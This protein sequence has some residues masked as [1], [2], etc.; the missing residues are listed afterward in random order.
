MKNIFF[1]LQCCFLLLLIISANSSRAQYNADAANSKLV[2]RELAIPTSPLFDLMGAA[3]S[4]VARTADIKDFKVDWSLKN[5]KVNPN[6]SIQAQPVWELFY[7]RKNLAKYQQANTFQRMM[8]SLDLSLGT[9]LGDN[10]ERRIGGA[11]KMSLY[12]QRDPLLMK[13]VYDDIQK[14]F[15]EELLQLKQKEKEIL[16]ALDSIVKPSELAAKREELRNN[17][18]QLTSFYSRRNTAIQNQAAQFVSDNWNAAYVD[19]AFGKIYSYSTDSAGSLGKLSLNRNTGN[20]L[21]LNFG[22]GVGKRGLIS[23]L[24]RSSFYEEEL[25][26]TVK[27]DVS[28]NENIQQAIAANKLFTFGIN[29][30]YGGP[31]FNF[32]AEFIREAKS[33]KTPLQA[34]NDVLDLPDGKTVVT[35]TVKWDV[36]HPY[37]INFGGDWRISRNVILNYGMRCVLDKNF[38]T[39]SFLPIANISCMMR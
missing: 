23:A 15:D 9:A 6:L 16:L 1:C 17:D 8:A 35:S 29:F 36:V 14:T 7:N 20:A 32:F 34:L 19:L 4:Q 28:G 26:F 3:P 22:F 37:I 5:W 24:I 18:A 11:L 12:K 25:T 13:G 31:V 30:R 10:N 2:P 39:V 38:K 21:W 27:D 33:L